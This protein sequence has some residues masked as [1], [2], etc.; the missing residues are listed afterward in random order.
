MTPRVERKT[1]NLTND[2]YQIYDR[3]YKLRKK[4]ICYTIMFNDVIVAYGL[5]T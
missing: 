3:F 4:T 2:V 5:I 1:R